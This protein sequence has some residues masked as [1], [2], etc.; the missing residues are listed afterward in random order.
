MPQQ[1]QDALTRLLVE[2]TRRL[3]SQHQLRLVDQ[4]SRHRQPLLLAARE[5]AGQ[6]ARRL[7]DTQPIDQLERPLASHGTVAGQPGGK[8]HVLLARQLR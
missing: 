2:V 3:V 7:T 5:H 1:Q 8:Q 6:V 4:R